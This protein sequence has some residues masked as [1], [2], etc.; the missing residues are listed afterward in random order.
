MPSLPTFL[1]PS[2]AARRL[3]VR[4]ALFALLVAALVPTFSRLMSPV[5]LAD[6][7]TLCQAAQAD[8]DSRAG[9]TSSPTPDAHAPGDACALCSLAHTT[10]AL[11]GSALPAVAVLAY[12]PPAPPAPA[13]VRTRVA[14]SRAPG[15]RAPPSLV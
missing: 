15:A 10:P 4:L 9:S 6:G 2:L 8:G 14:Q 13:V 11:G 5:G 12:A 3:S 1:R 7:S